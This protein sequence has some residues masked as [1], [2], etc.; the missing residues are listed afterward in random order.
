MTTDKGLNWK[1]VILNG[2]PGSGKDSL[3]NLLA[4]G[5]N[6]KQQEFKAPLYR[7]GAAM[8][9]IALPQFLFL[10]QDRTWKEAKRP[11]LMGMSI[12]DL[13]IWYSEEVI[14][15]K[16]GKAWFGVQACNSSNIFD[17]VNHGIYFTDGGFIEELAPLV[18]RFGADNF[19]IARIHRDGCNFASD[20][21]RYL[22]DQELKDIGVNTV[23]DL[24]NNGTKMEL[25]E[26]FKDKLSLSLGM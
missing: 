7:F 16:F 1:I 2:P 12:R 26:Q 11:E 4:T 24:D 25:Y 8:L 5:M 20:S 23:F 10:Y 6:A 17:W 9:N 19:I 3:G 14:K 21:R 22:E 13:F 15:P 18:E